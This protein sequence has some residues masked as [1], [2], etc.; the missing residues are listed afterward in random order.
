MRFPARPAT[1]FISCAV[2]ALLGFILTD[3]VKPMRAWLTVAIAI[4]MVLIV[5]VVAG[6]VERRL[7]R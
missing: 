1:I 3:I 7:S 5:M 2:W 4:A 6:A